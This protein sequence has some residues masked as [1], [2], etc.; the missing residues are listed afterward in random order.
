MNTMRNAGAAKKALTLLKP[1]VQ[2]LI[3]IKDKDA[4]CMWEGLAN[5][6]K[7]QTSA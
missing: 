5:T 7:A 4:S 1:E 2:H 3:H 6:L